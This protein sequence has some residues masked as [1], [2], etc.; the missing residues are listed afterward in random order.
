MA[1]VWSLNGSENDS[2]S[3]ISY[4]PYINRAAKQPAAAT[5]SLLENGANVTGLEGPCKILREP[6]MS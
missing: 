2:L 4:I 5:V 3:S 6:F 1:S